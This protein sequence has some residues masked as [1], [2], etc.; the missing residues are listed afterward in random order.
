MAPLERHQ[1]LCYCCGDV[2]ETEADG[3][4][5]GVFTPETIEHMLLRCPHPLLIEARAGM[6]TAL[7]AVAV[8]V[9]QSVEARDV[10]AAIP[11]PDFDNDTALWTV[12]MLCG[13]LGPVQHM[14]LLQPMP[15]AV[16]A[17]AVRA[18]GPAVMFEPEV[19]RQVSQ[20]L[21]ALTR[22]WVDKMRAPRYDAAVV[23]QLPGGRLVNEMVRCATNMFVVHRRCLRDSRAY[24]TRARDPAVERAKRSPPKMTEVDKKS[25]TAKR[26]EAKKRSIGPVVALLARQNQANK[27]AVRVARRAVQEQAR[28]AKKVAR[29]QALARARKQDQQEDQADKAR[30]R[31]HGVEARAK[32]A[33]ARQDQE[34]ATTVADGRALGAPIPARSRR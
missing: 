13:S 3:G 34:A 4:E 5:V 20:W 1:R 30:A 10:T 26:K 9:A 25:R 22:Q 15:M 31:A 14:H 6:R 12:F 28:R 17:P 23:D 16:A 27:E 33:K 7:Q 32:R 21:G 8:A 2:H 11:C 24:L 29:R 18:S 19:A